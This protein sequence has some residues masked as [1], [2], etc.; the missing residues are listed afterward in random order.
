MNCNNC[1]G[2]M[3]YDIESYG[4]V[5]DSCGA[6]RKLRRPEEGV[7]VGETDLTDAVR[8]AGKDWGVSSRIVECNSCGARM[9]YANDQLS[10]M[11]P[12]CGSSVV[13]SAE[14]A[15]CGIA[16]NAIIPFSI[17]KDDVIKRF[18]RWN[19]FAFW[20]PEK[21]RKGKVLG[22][23]T[24]LYVPFW[25]FSADAVITYS[26]RFG[27]EIGTGDDRKVS[28]KIK[29]GIAETHIS[30]QSICGSR[31]FSSDA[32]LN[33]VAAFK[34]EDLVEYSPDI[35]SG[36][37]AEIYTVGVD[38]A[39][40]NVMRGKF[41]KLAMDAAMKHEG[42]DL[43]KDM[44]FSVEYSNI[45]FRYALIPVWL[46]GC[47]YKGKIYNMVS[48]GYDLRGN[49]NRP[50]SVLKLV[51]PLILLF[52]GTLLSYR[53]GFPGLFIDAVIVLVA[54]AIIAYTVVF[55]KTLAAQNAEARKKRP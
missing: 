10:G 47:R 42:A 14:D 6:V 28:W 26:A 22:N 50:V 37:A 19:R 12:F 2:T 52:I 29:N 30:D 11:C 20:A 8:A 55:I 53:L 5:C 4:L 54:V 43:Y 46:S 39:W 45:K 17:P 1:G 40:N 38:E 34:T 18:Y 9:I 24:P 32:M 31:K 16:P 23:P 13:L 27:Y 25:T 7:I 15:D 44:R 41:R 48:S 49:C 3:R 36:M 51:V 21:F 33:K 35:L